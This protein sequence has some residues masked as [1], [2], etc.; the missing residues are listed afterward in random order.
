MYNM[1]FF[2]PNIIMNMIMAK[3]TQ[4]N[5]IFLLMVF[6]IPIFM[7]YFYSSG[8]NFI[9]RFITAFASLFF[10]F[11]SV[12]S[13]NTVFIVGTGVFFFGI[14]CF[15]PAFLGTIFRFSNKEW[16]GFKYLRGLHTRG[17]FSLRKLFGKI[18]VKTFFST[19][20]SSFC[21]RFLNQKFGFA[22]RT[23]NFLS[24]LLK[25]TSTYRG[26]YRIF[27]INLF[28]R[29]WVFTNQTIFKQHRR[30]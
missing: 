19:K 20:F 1:T 13:S 10:I 15:M 7:M 30:I 12:I 21:Q 29:E 5:Q 17:Q 24:S 25:N 23:F 26:T 2:I 6:S 9:S 3:R 18:N 11:S 16:S 22:N 8:T 28:V 4:T 27:F 14:S